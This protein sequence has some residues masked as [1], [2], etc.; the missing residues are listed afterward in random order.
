M[1]P[2]FHFRNTVHLRSH[3][4]GPRL[5]RAYYVIHALIS[6][7]SYDTGITSVR[8]GVNLLSVTQQRSNSNADFPDAKAFNHY[9]HNL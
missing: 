2:P 1:L 7:Q 3:H 5:L 8:G 6:H 4:S 9:I